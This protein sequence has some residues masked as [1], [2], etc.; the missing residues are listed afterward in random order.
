MKN[1][2]QFITEGRYEAGMKF[3]IKVKAYD[4]Y[5]DDDIEIL[6][7]VEGIDK[8]IVDGSLTLPK[9][10]IVEL[11]WGDTPYS[12]YVFNIFFPDGDVVNDVPAF[13]EWAFDDCMDDL[14]RASKIVK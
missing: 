11:D 9:G 6:D 13:G 14:K 12:R 10:T 1:L 4:L 3:Q 7:G 5:S 8:H 2:L